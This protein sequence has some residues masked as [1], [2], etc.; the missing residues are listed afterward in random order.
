[1]QRYHIVT[2]LNFN[3]V[4]DVSTTALTINQYS[5]MR[6]RTVCFS[7]LFPAPFFFFLFCFSLFFFF[8]RGKKEI[9]LII[10][11]ARRSTLHLRGVASIVSVSTISPL[12]CQHASQT[13]VIA[14]QPGF[15]RKS[16]LFI[17]GL[18]DD[19][20]DRYVISTSH[21]QQEAE[22]AG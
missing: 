2:R 17:A 3:R 11:F 6:M 7:L 8:T 5:G 9:I 22:R 4:L 1:M 13:L 12:S 15:L 19:E 14:V 10:K 16:S 21:V 20:I 18:P